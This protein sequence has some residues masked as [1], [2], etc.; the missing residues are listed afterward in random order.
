M[1]KVHTNFEIAETGLIIEPLY[2]FM[3]ASPDAVVSCTYCG[4]GVLEVKCPF[5]CKDKDFQSVANSNS[6]FFC[7]QM[8]MGN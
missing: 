4:N 8:M 3:G 5:S 6:N 1:S 2:P 7:M